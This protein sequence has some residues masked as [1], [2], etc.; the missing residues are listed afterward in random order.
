M[1][2]SLLSDTQKAALVA[3]AERH[4]PTFQTI[5][6]IHKEPTQTVTSN[7][8]NIFPGY[9]STSTET[10][11]SYTPVSQSFSGLIT[12]MSNKDPHELYEIN[13]RIWKGDARIKVQ[14]DA[15]DYI[16]NGKTIK[17][18]ADNKNWD[19]IS[20]PSTQTFFTL[21]YFYFDLK[22]IH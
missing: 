16:L 4:M 18:V 19:V 5:I 7:A 13:K 14:Q 12:K 3:V 21:E 6:T 2:T 11:I 17:V 1:A 22:E 9:K 10:N 15:R 20:G 8:T